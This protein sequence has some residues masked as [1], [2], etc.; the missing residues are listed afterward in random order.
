MPHVIEPAAGADRAMLAF[1]VDAY[2]EDEIAGE[3]RTVLRLHPVLAPVKRDGSSE[4]LTGANAGQLIG[5]SNQNQPTSRTDRPDQRAGKTGIQH[6]CL[7]H[8]HHVIGE[9]IARPVLK[10]FGG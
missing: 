5:V 1:L 7:V 10:A 3:Q 8:D 2:D 4:H 9:R 6:A